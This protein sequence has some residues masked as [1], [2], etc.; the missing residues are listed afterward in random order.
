MLH[1]LAWKP[2]SEDTSPNTFSYMSDYN[3]ILESI[4]RYVFRNC[5]V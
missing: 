2:L 5:Q 4:L 1:G 3:L